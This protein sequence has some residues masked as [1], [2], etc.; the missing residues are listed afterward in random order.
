MFQWNAQETG[1]RWMTSRNPNPI[2]MRS[3]LVEYHRSPFFGYSTSYAAHLH[4]TKHQHCLG[5][6]Y[7]AG[8][9][10]W[11]A[12]RKSITAT[13]LVHFPYETELAAGQLLGH[14]QTHAGHLFFAFARQGL[15][16]HLVD[17]I[18]LGALPAQL[19]LRPLAV[20]GQLVG[21]H[22]PL[23]DDRQPLQVACGLD[24]IVV[25]PGFHRLHR[26]LLVP[27]AGDHH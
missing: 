16:K 19:L 4:V 20:Q 25:G 7:R 24:H 26:H 11:I 8:I 17:P 22:G 14:G 13:R 3:G 15:Q 12:N 18:Q 9:P 21:L 1:D 5:L 23:G 27:T 2:Q 10:A 6:R